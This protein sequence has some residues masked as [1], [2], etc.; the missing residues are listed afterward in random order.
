MVDP[1][2]DGGVEFREG[3]LSGFV[4]VEVA[5]QPPGELNSVAALLPS[6][7]WMDDESEPGDSFSRGNNLRL[8]HVNG[9]TEP[10]EP[11]HGGRFPLPELALVVA[12]QGEVVHVAQICAASKFPLRE[13]VQGK[14]RDQLSCSLVSQIPGWDTLNIAGFDPHDKRVHRWRV[15]GVLG[16]GTERTNRP[17]IRSVQACGKRLAAHCPNRPPALTIHVPWTAL[18]QRTRHDSGTYRILPGRAGKSEHAAC[19]HS[20]FRAR[21]V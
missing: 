6:E 18:N 3:D 20:Q 5:A 7:V 12:K 1:P 4:K 9:Q 16:H 19:K 10:L 8:W 15:G 2:A 14:Q 17:T 11:F 21:E 13:P